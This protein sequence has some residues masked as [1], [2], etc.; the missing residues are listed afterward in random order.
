MEALAPET[1]GS[2]HVKNMCRS[3]PASTKPKSKLRTSIRARFHATREK[4]TSLWER[5]HRVSR[6]TLQNT[7][8]AEILTLSLSVVSLATIAVVVL[9]YDG[10]AAPSLPRGITL[11]AVVSILA[12]ISKSALLFAVAACISQLKWSRF[13]NQQHLNDAQILEDA[14]RGPLGSMKLLTT[15]LARS[16]A[17]I[18]AL[19]T[20]LAL[21]YDPFLQQLIRYP[22]K[23]VYRNSTLAITRRA[24]SF[25]VYMLD[26]AFTSAV[27]EGIWST[28]VL[29]EPDCPTGNCS[30]PMYTSV[31]WCSK[32]QDLT[33][34]SVLRD[35]ELKRPDMND[36]A[37]VSTEIPCRVELSDGRTIT[38]PIAFTTA[39]DNAQAQFTTFNYL[40]VPLSDPPN[41]APYPYDYLSLS[42]QYYVGVENP[43]LSMGYVD[44]NSESPEYGKA[45]PLNSVQECVIDICFTEYKAAVHEGTPDMTSSRTYHGQ[46]FQELLTSPL[47]SGGSTTYHCWREP[48]VP[49]SGLEF[50]SIYSKAIA[51]R[52]DIRVDTNNR[53]FCLE[54]QT[55]TETGNVI[56]MCLGRFWATEIA[57]RLWSNT[58]VRN[59]H[60]DNYIS[61][62]YGLNN[63]SD[64]IQR[65]MKTGLESV[66]SSI[67]TSLTNLAFAA[68]PSHNVVYGQAALPVT[69]V[70][71]RFEW[72]I[73]PALLEV[74]AIVL[75][76]LTKLV[77]RKTGAPLWKDS[78]LATFF[79]GFEEELRAGLTGIGATVTAM[80]EEAKKTR[81]R[82]KMRKE[83]GGGDT[84][85]FGL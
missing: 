51:D 50:H 80:E 9:I 18:G 70:E 71:V 23:E 25:D 20:V 74:A 46:Q 85:M 62:P 45:P 77:T 2:D 40:A 38:A 79:H 72:M 55:E 73:L 65:L 10:H 52:C 39:V 31:G 22:V 54:M 11:N 30:W 58:T 26:L 13:H 42:T 12:T 57:Q 6:F 64:V 76:V 29:K 15:R 36:S 61:T 44:M 5:A 32:C 75:L 8:L 17:S 83:E 67:A 82:L 78:L 7:W 34:D 56:R 81:V 53:A 28:P 69:H 16:V 48:D 27:N 59:L 21:G 1:S 66:T 43:V 49:E 35:C 24:S 14:S 3:L 63:H 4:L 41:E 47:Y 68:E 33:H 37:V 19:T 84:W 60:I